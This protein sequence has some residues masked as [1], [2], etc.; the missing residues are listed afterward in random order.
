MGGRHGAGENSGAARG[1]GRQPRTPR[2][3]AWMRGPRCCRTRCCRSSRRLLSYI[4][5]SAIAHLLCAYRSTLIK[6]HP[7][8]NENHPNA[9]ERTLLSSASNCRRL[10]ARDTRG[11]GCR[12]GRL[13]RGVWACA[14][15]LAGP[16]V[17][18]AWYCFG[19]REHDRVPLVGPLPPHGP[20]RRDGRKHAHE[21][22]PG[23]P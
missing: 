15:L 16:P 23:A 7:H 1:G 6:V 11:D 14:R 2:A 8:A 20:G 4:L 22:A 5:P 21:A 12:V 13:R 3:R 10:D 9:E 18:D 19:Y 17:C